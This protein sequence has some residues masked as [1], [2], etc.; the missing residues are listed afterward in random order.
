MPRHKRAVA[1]LA[2]LDPA[3]GELVRR[4][5]TRCGSEALAIV[6]ALAR[7]VLGVDTFFDWTSDPD[8]IGDKGST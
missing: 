3:A 6:E 5:A 7:R 1:A 2:E 8:P 4:W